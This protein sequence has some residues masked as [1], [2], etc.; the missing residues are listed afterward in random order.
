MRVLAGGGDRAAADVSDAAAL[1][2]TPTA[3][4][5]RVVTLVPVSVVVPP[6]AVKTPAI[7]A[8]LVA[9]EEFVIFATPP[10]TEASKGPLKRPYE[11]LPVAGSAT[12]RVVTVTFAASSSEPAS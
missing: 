5:P 1:N 6:V 4:T 7:C 2:S 3:P 12:P 9:I 10:A 8:P 11:G